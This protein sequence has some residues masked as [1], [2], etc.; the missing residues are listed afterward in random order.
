MIAK[1]DFKFDAAIFVD[2][3]IDCNIR[4]WKTDKD[5]DGDPEFNVT[6]DLPGEA[7]DQEWS[8]EIPAKKVLTEGIGGVINAAVDAVPDFPLKNIVL[9]MLKEITG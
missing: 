6:I 9:K 3:I 4:V 2:S 1:I 8:V 5:K 7:F